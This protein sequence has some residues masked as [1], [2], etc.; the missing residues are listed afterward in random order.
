MENYFN[1]KY[2]PYKHLTIKDREKILLYL[3]K[4]LSVRAVSQKLNRQPSTISR[5]INRNLDDNGNYSPNKA[6]KRAKRERQNSRLGKFKIL[7][8]A[9]IY[10]YTLDK[11]EQGWSP[12]QIAGRIKK[13]LGL[14]VVHE[15]IYRFIYSYFGKKD[16]LR[17]Y[18]RRNHRIRKKN[19]NPRKTQNR[20][21]IPNRI[22]ISLRPKSVESRK[23]AG[24]WE[25]DTVIGKGHKSALVTLVERKTKYLAMDK[26]SNKDSIPTANSIVNLFKIFPYKLR[27]TITFDNGL[28]FAAHENITKKINTRCF[29]AETYSSWQRG[30]N[31]NTNGLI[32]WYL[33]KGTDFNE[34][35]K[36]TLEAII[37][38]LNNRPR[39]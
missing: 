19:G 15:T 8:S 23:I 25:G 38:A 35:D 14:S 36:P 22:D 16:D 31:E 33:P 24:H 13:D 27:K 9:D 6:Q 37:K 26:L 10:N 32:R 34:L 17:K 18:L 28:E 3:G 4:G 7:A 1:T 21:K 39:K 11:L 20:S 2:M 29:F 30:T 5:E 12:E